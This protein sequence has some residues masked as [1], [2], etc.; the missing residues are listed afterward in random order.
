VHHSD[1]SLYYYHMDHKKDVLGTNCC[2][3]SAEVDD[4]VKISF[5]RYQQFFGAA[6]D[7][8]VLLPE[9]NYLLI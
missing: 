3:Y 7:V 5:R 4:G 2:V 6:D 1:C 9:R 8:A